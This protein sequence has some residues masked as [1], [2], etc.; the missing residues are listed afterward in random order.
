MKYPQ[1]FNHQEFQVP[2]MELLLRY[3]TLFQASKRLNNFKQKNTGEVSQLA[4]I[5]D[6]CL[7]FRFPFTKM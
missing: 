4:P 1:V 5:E 3:R 2:K 6:A 7:F